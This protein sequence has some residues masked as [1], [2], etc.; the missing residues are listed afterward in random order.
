MLYDIHTHTPGARVGCISI[1]NVAVR[2]SD[3]VLPEG[4][5]SVG[6]HPWHVETGKPTAALEA[7]AQLATKH[8]V[9]AVGECGIDRAIPTHVDVQT[10]VFLAQVRMAESIGKPV[11][12]H[13][14]RSGSDVLALRRY[15]EMSLPWIIH[16]YTGGPDLAEQLL[17]KGI[18]LSFGAA[19]LDSR[20]KTSEVFRLLPLEKI[21]L[22]TDE[23][24]VDIARIYEA[25]A[26]LRG[27]SVATL[28][29]II[30]A[31]VS[32]TFSGIDSSPRSAPL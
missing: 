3:P 16:G 10:E 14:V 23:H 24:D 6:V 17:S 26:G 29:D 13:S 8:N 22:E 12:I 28:V 18:L 1:L 32:T 2:A 19:L 4:Y 27:M 15:S 5:C 31:T 11:I 7:V 9:L 25:A 21:L 20:R 30:S